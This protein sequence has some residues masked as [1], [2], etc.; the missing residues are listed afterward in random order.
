MSTTWVLCFTIWAISLE[1]ANYERGLRI[2]EAVYGPEHP[3]VA[4]QLGNLGRVLQDL[5][6]VAGA[7]ANFERALKIFK[8][9]FGDDHPNTRIVQRNLDLLAIEENKQKKSR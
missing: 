4:T 8:K 1:R 7:R 9:F 3:N 6:D 5:G 2:S